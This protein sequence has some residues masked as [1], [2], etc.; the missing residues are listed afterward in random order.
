MSK[1]R[2]GDMEAFA[3]ELRSEGYEKVNLIDT[4]N[5]KFMTPIEAKLMALSGSTL[6]VGIK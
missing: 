4:T 2:Y 6:L 5:G 1:G 3:D